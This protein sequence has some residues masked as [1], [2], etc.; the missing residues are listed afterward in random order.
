MSTSGGLVT[1]NSLSPPVSVTGTNPAT[2]PLSIV[3]AAAQASDLFDITASGGAAGGTFAVA[4]VANP[5][6]GIRVTNAAAGNAPVIAATGT[7]GV[8]DISLTPKGSGAVRL[9]GV[10]VIS[11][12][13][14][15]PAAGFL[16]NTGAGPGTTW[17]TPGSVAAAVN[18]V[19]VTNAA[20]GNPPVIAA[21]GTDAAVGL[22][23]QTRNAS[24]P[25]NALSIAA[26]GQATFPVAPVFG[27]NGTFSSGATM[28]VSN[29]TLATG[30]VVLA[31][32]SAVF[33]AQG[34][35]G[36]V[37]GVTVTAAAT[38]VAP[39]IT[40]VGTDTNIDLSLVSKGS[41]VVRTTSAV[42]G[43]VGAFIGFY[44]VT[45]VA[46]AAAITA[47]AATASTNVTPFGFTTAAQA[48]A[49]VAAVR[50]M[51]VALQNIGVTL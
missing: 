45:A 41:G 31:T 1:A 49:L 21:T 32:S 15:I 9:N 26:N 20:T 29:S 13:S 17:L 35:T 27:A 14:W 7:D 30:S 48:D 33:T 22:I 18:N 43:G 19:Q 6:N 8:I 50:A 12:G 5:V 36:Q 51:Q 28:T 23:L 38:T 11:G 24:A 25:V 37:N 16:A 47:P 40:A 3:G 34:A 46:R 39:T 2:V 44:G 10:V 42:I 4:T